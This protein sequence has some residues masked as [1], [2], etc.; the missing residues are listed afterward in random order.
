MPFAPKR[1]HPRSSRDVAG[2]Y[3][4]NGLEVLLTLAELSGMLRGIEADIKRSL[5]TAEVQSLENYNDDGA[6]HYAL[7][8]PVW[9]R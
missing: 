4:S 9:G 1:A 3:E 7:A 5:G 8:R 6:R 2:N